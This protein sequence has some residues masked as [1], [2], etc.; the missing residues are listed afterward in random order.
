M[1]VGGG[2]GGPTKS[3]NV[4]KQVPNN[5]PST[6]TNNVTSVFYEALIIKR[7]VV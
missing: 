2:D 6:Q 7:A 3:P 4:A 5:M 1:G